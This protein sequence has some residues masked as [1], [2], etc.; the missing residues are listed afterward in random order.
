MA[1]NAHPEVT[2]RRI[3][4]A[5]RELFL[6]KGYENT[7]I[8]DIVDRL[9]DLSKGAIYHHFKSKKA[10][11]DKLTDYDWEQADAEHAELLARTDLT[12]LEKLRELF[13]TTVS[14][15]Q[16]NQINQLSIPFLDDPQTLA[17]NLQFWSHELP[18]HWMPFLEN[19]IRDGSIPTEYPREASELLSLLANYWLLTHFYPATRNELHHRIECLATMLNAINVPVFDDELITMTTDFYMSYNSQAASKTA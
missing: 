1:R 17:S 9:G 16:H 2:E 3:V 12:G 18:K 11:L 10:I 7:S 5:A 14:N 4:N 15:K 6:E 8:Q 13:K 19:G